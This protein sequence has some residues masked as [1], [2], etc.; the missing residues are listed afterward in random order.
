VAVC[1][2]PATYVGMHSQVLGPAV[3]HW[4]TEMANW[5]VSILL[6]LDTQFKESKTS[7]FLV[8]G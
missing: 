7:D 2:I 4:D 8:I 6:P 3:L 5:Q 1:L